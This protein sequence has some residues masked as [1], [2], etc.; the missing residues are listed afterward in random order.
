MNRYDTSAFQQIWKS[1]L[2]YPTVKIAV[3]DGPVDTT[4][5]SLQDAQLSKLPTLVSSAPGVGRMSEHGTHITSVIFGQHDSEIRGIAPA[6]NGIIA[7]IFSD[8][9]ARLSQL[10]LARAIN[11][12]LDQ[13]AHVINISGGELSAPDA[14]ETILAEAVQACHK[15]GVLIVAAAGN[16]GC[17]CLHLPA[18]L[19]AVL[20]VGALD[21]RGH[22]FDFSNWG[23]TYQTNGILAPGE[24]ILGA[25]PGGGSARKSGTSFATPIVTGLIG[26]MLS[27]QIQQGQ[28]PNPYQIKEA[29]L[30]TALSCA[31]DTGKR[32]LTG[33]LDI[34]EVYN[35]IVNQSE[36]TV[37]ET[38]SASSAQIGI[39]MSNINPSESH[40]AEF[41][42]SMGQPNSPIYPQATVLATQPENYAP[43]ANTPQTLTDQN[44]PVGVLSASGM[45]TPNGQPIPTY[46][47]SQ[48]TPTYP[49]AGMTNNIQGLQ[50]SS[51]ETNQ[52]V[53]N[54]PAQ[55]AST[56]MPQN[57]PTVN[58]VAPSAVAPSEGCG[59]DSSPSSLIYA[60]GVIGYDFAT[61]ARR[62]SFKQLMPVVNANNSAES[63]PDGNVPDGTIAIP[64]NPYDARQMVNY[65]LGS[66]RGDGQA[67]NGNPEEAAS[68]IWTLNL[69]LTPIYAIEPKG[70][71][72][73]VV[74]KQMAEFLAGQILASNSNE[75]IERISLPGVLTGKTVRLF[76]G[77]VVPVIEPLN[78][79]GMYAWNTNQLISSVMAAIAGD[80][81][82]SGLGDAERGEVEYALRSFLQRIYY[83]LRNLGQTAQERALNY[84]SA[85]VFQFSDAM[86]DVLRN[87]QR[88]GGGTDMA[89]AMQLDSIAVEKS[90]FCRVDSD[91]WDV[92][93]TFFDP[94]NDRRARRVLRYT[95]DVSDLM[96]VT[97]GQPRIWDIS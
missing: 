81:N 46:P 67:A 50:A 84:A 54:V 66:P 28:S 23:E 33:R 29:I 82:E 45:A 38:V 26:L 34:L 36:I 18:A 37:S 22:P 90:P 58:Q 2:G 91:C 52:V 24:Q 85:N 44:V 41:D 88:V 30:R 60:I 49:P 12:A 14:A 97:I 71:F 15:A 86:V 5:P 31:S 62:D 6:C 13:G 3:L 59:C 21:I 11:Q 48:S 53:A 69:E 7:P 92:K 40:T 17:D 20:A 93:I 16:D 64:A 51:P 65:L 1:T 68:L 35:T 27:L 94:E 83:D 43:P 75:Y 78:T 39:N 87:R 76:S 57:Y 47:G 96:P 9:K 80:N 73:Y 25:M 19:P 32:C 79:R 77:Q 74:Y 70:A 8:D 10:D 63:F 61:E 89:V 95:I 55:F 42:N 56:P 72:G 4:H